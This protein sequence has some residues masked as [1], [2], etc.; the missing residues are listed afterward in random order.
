MHAQTHIAP[1]DTGFTNTLVINLLI[2][3]YFIDSIYVIECMKG[4]TWMHTVKLKLSIENVYAGV[5]GFGSTTSLSKSLKSSNSTSF[6]K[7]K[8]SPAPMFQLCFEHRRL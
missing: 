2:I 3:G 7:T 1:G 5:A 6:E 8:N 4:S